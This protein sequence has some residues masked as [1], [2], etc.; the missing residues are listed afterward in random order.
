[1]IAC[2]ILFATWGHDIQLSRKFLV[3]EA[4]P[5]VFGIIV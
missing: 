3:I 4:F 2:N 5:K 1:M